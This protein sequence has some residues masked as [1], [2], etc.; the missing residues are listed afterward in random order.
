M[1][2]VIAQAI[3]LGEQLKTFFERRKDR[4]SHPLE[5]LQ[6]RIGDCDCK[7]IL[8]AS[9]LETI[10]HKT[11]LV[12]YP[13]HVFVQVHIENADVVRLPSKDFGFG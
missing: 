3:V 4:F 10:G 11:E 8:L 5:T 9:L 13:G 1:V 12:L 6:L 7:S 2:A